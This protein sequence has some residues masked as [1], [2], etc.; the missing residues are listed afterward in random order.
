MK[1]LFVYNYGKVP[2]YPIGIGILSSM[3]KMSGHET[4]LVCLSVGESEKKLMNTAQTWKPDIVAFSS[5]S[6]MFE[7]IK[8]LSAQTRASLP[9]TFQICGGIHTTLIPECL[10][11]TDLDAVCIGEGEYAIVDL[12]EKRGENKTYT[13][14]G[15]FWF[16]GADKEV[17]KN[18]PA[19]LVQDLDA[20]P[21]PDYD[22]YYSQD[23]SGKVEGRAEFLFCR[24][25]PFDCTYC[26]N[27]AIKSLHG[28]QRY[29]R[30]PTVEKAIE[31]VKYVTKKHN[32]KYV[33][34]NDDIITLNRTW[35]YDFFNE[36]KRK[37]A[38][39]FYCNIRPKTC[40][41]AMFKMLKEA[42]CDSVAIGV[43]SGNTYIRKKIL[44]RDISDDDILTTFKLAQGYGL[45]TLSFSMVGIPYETKEKI[46]ETVTFLARL[47]ENN[48]SWFS[49]FHP[50]PKTKLYDLCLE[51][52]WIDSKLKDYSAERTVSVLKLP[53]VSSKDISAYHKLFHILIQIEHIL[54]KNTSQYKRKIIR[55]LYMYP[56][57]PYMLLLF[58]YFHKFRM[59]GPKKAILRIWQRIT[60]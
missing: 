58:H 14:I 38:I 51:K 28:K 3:L 5:M 30:Y 32:I 59:Y 40:D 49:V 8:I 24:G 42:N 25:C 11:G 7:R 57:Y 55:Y 13:N 34:F 35:F 31:E 12:L 16:K 23:I 37:I 60:T 52:G 9:D 17:I 29:I 41:A 10:E 2:Q 15:G 6:S 53:D 56:R 1:V 43:E 20:L 45:K 27:H 48:S 50:Y 26:S 4:K 22:I 44:N 39:P 46:I 19:P 21:M 36:Y 33:V 47:G 54:S 18:S